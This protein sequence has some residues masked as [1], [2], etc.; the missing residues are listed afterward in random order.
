MFIQLLRGFSWIALSLASMAALAADPSLAT[1]P[2]ATVVDPDQRLACYDSAFPPAG[3]AR[4]GAFD[5]VA[6]RAKALRDF[7]LNRE[8]L[9]VRQPEHVLALEP[10]RIEGKI[11]RI[12]QLATG[13]R[14]ITLE[15]KQVWL[16]TEVS[17]RGYLREGESVTI[18]TAALGTFMLITPR[19]VPL[20]ARR[21]Q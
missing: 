5:P 9:R 8:Q 17:S 10:D 11:L 7:G 20:R 12:S 6:E 18:K 15:N 14:R 1:H 19:R 16:L 21:L 13:E 2:C 3:G 4:S